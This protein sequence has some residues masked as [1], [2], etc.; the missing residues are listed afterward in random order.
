MRK[1][2]VQ[3]SIGLVCFLLAF[4]ITY[5]FKQINKKNSTLNVAKNNPNIVI[6]IQQLKKEKEELEKKIN[7]LQS[8]IQGYEDETVGRNKM[9]QQLKD[10]LDET[11]LILGETDVEGEG[12][13]IYITPRSDI[14]NVGYE[15]TPINDR[16]LLYI[17]NEL[18]AVGAEAISINDIRL[19]VNSGIRTAGN[20]IRIGNDKISPFERVTIKVIGNK[21]NIKGALEFPG[22]IPETLNNTC[23]IKWEP[24]DDLF[25][26]KSNNI[27]KIEY[28]KEVKSE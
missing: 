12:Y 7:D 8:K 26:K 25:I 5:Q 24:K 13:I 11:R 15:M 10:E 19:T 9:M 14:F 21:E 6:E 4:M 3:L 18:Y 27:Y 28:A 22:N 20:A 2:K 1:I 16:D 23:D 17:I